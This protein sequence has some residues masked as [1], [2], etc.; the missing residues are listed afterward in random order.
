M[1]SALFQLAELALR[2]EVILMKALASENV[3]K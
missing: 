1:H 3:I 2:K